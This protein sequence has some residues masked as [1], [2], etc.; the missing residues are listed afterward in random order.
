MKNEDSPK[1]AETKANLHRPTVQISQ[2]E[3]DIILFQFEA[4]TR[5]IFIPFG[6]YLRTEHQNW[7]TPIRLI[8][9]FRGAGVPSRFMIDRAPRIFTEI[10]LA[11]DTRIACLVDDNSI[12]HLIHRALEK[13]RESVPQI[14]SFLNFDPAIEW[15]LE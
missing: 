9:D 6:D 4:L 14:S 3:N 7:E 5:E 1:L 10:N 11:N 12:G 2:L 8:F 13:W 15:M